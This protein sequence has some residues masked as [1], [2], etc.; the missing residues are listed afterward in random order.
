MRIRSYLLITVILAAVGGAHADTID[1]D[2]VSLAIR[3]LPGYC[4]STDQDLLGPMNRMMTKLKDIAVSAPCGEL[5]AFRSG[6]ATLGSYIVWTVGTSDSGTAERLPG[7]V[8]RKTFAAEM[9]TGQSRA[10]ISN[11][12]A[13]ANNKLEQEKMGSLSNPSV[14]LIEQ[15]S[16]AIYTAVVVDTSVGGVS[17]RK[18]IVMGSAAVQHLPVT[19]D[20]YD[21]F[22]GPETFTRLLDEVRSLMQGALADNPD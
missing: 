18:A 4:T 13:D 20:A 11:I 22:S 1:V 12:I 3:N 19:I 7:E 2:G 10:S 6:T 17:Q 16:E 14:G 9:A 21:Q 15:D 5:Q 8:T